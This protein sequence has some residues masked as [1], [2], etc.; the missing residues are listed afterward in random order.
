VTII[1]EAP[2]ELVGTSIAASPGYSFGRAG[3]LIANTY[4][5]R[6]GGTP[7][8]N[9]GVNF[10]LTSG[11]LD[12]VATGTKSADTYTLTISQHDGNNASPT[13]IAV[14]SVTALTKAILLK[15]VDFVQVGALIKNRQV[16]VEVTTGTA[17][18]IGVDLQ[19]SGS[20]T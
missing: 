15:D 5:N 8:N 14:V 4:L 20:L 2:C 3:V 11:S 12:I 10:G 13:V 6:P 17:N 18:N 9:T 19:F 7:S 16:A 1:L